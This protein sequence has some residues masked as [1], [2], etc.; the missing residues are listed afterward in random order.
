MADMSTPAPPKRRLRRELR[1]W[2]AFA[3]SIGLASPMLAMS[4]SGIGAAGYVGR[5]VPLAFLLAGVVLLFIASGMVIVSRNFSHAGSVYG[6]TGATI[7]PRAGFFSGW[8][9]A[10]CYLVFTPGSL[11]A[12]GYFVALFCQDTGIWKDAVDHFVWFAVG[13]LI[14]CWLLNLVQVR[15]LTRS[16]LSIEG[17][18]V[19][20]L[21]ILMIV[22]VVRLAV[23][24][25]PYPGATLTLAVL[26]P[27]IGGLHGL[28]LAS[29]FAFI[30]FAG[31]EA[32]MSLGEE[33]HEPKRT[34]PRALII[35][36]IAIGVFY[37]LCMMS[38]ALGFGATLKGGQTFAG[39]TGPVFQLAASY[40]GAPMAWALEL[41]AAVSAFGSALASAAGCARL[42]YAM[43]RDAR[44]DSRL[45]TVTQRTSAPGAALAFVMVFSVL[46]LLILVLAGNTGLDI[47]NYMGTLGTL[48]LLVTYALINVGAVRLVLT[49]RSTVQVAACVG[50]ALAVLFLA[51]VLF[52]QVYPAPPVPFNLLPYMCIGWLAL[53]LLIVL[54]V[55]GL[56]KRIGR[57]LAVEEGLIADQEAKTE[58]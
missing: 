33:T 15:N 36:T 12:A 6:L 10:G 52:N 53:G 41:G 4:F 51:F 55:P 7:G 2:E 38:Q 28:A 14:L 22:I 32:A 27:Q 57:G 37:F 54:I 43:A 18:S 44:P 11:A 39:S 34:I 56:A 17:V 24:T 5:A 29:V 21:L 31:F 45:A 1:L 19:T 40:V 3:L 8:A 9:L 58:A 47:W 26:V 46:A 20:I 30:A 49:G 25:S 13:F 42:I 50:P 35:A 48:L 23:G 16:M